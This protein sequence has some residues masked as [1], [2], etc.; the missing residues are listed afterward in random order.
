[1]ERRLAAVV[2]LVVAPAVLLLALYV[3]FDQFP[4]G[5]IV[6]ACVGVALVAAWYALLRKGIARAIGLAIALVALAVPVVLLVSDGDHLLEAMLIAAGLPISLAAAKFA[7]RV[8]VPLEPVP[9]PEHPVLFYNPKSG[10][11]KAERFALAKEARE[12]GI[13]PIEL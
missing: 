10:G 5:L 8:K 7:F 2:A 13:E 6:I 3:V 12:R 11:G 9:A 1:M 4:R